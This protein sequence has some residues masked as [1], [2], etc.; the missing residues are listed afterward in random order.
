MITVLP[1]REG[2]ISPW[3]HACAVLLR[4]AAG[5]AWRAIVAPGQ[6]SRIERSTGRVRGR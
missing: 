1:A 4:A 5:L 2:A 6:P 3:R